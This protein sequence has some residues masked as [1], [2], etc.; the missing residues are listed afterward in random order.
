M[1]DEQP[2][3]PADFMGKIVVVTGAASGIGFGIADAFVAAG[4]EVVVA[5]IEEQAATA[6]PARPGF[7]S[8]FQT[9]RRTTSTASLAH[10]QVW[11]GNTGMRATRRGGAKNRT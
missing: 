11:K 8:R 5:D 10:R 9:H 2:A 1:P 4:A 3:P 7:R 6:W